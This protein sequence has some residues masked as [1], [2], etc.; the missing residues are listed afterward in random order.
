MFKKVVSLFM[1][2]FCF[3]SLTISSSAKAYKDDRVLIIRNEN[4]DWNQCTAMPVSL[5]SEGM[6]VRQSE[7]YDAVYVNEM[8]DSF[9]KVDDLTYID[10]E[11]VSLPL[12]EYE[13]YLTLEGY[14]LPQEVLDSVARMAT[15]ANETQNTSA[16]VKFY[17]PTSL[18]RLQTYPRTQTTWNGK[19]FY[20]YQ[21]YFTDMY[22][23]SQV[24]SQGKSLSESVLSSIVEMIISVVGNKSENLEPVINLFSN[25]MSALEFWEESTGNTPIY[26]YASNKLEVDVCYDLYHKYTFYDDPNFGEEIFGCS[27]QKGKIKTVETTEYLYTENGGSRE[28]NTEIC[29]DWYYTPNFFSP[30]Q[31]AYYHTTSGWSE[32]LRAKVANK[33]FYF[34][35]PD[36]SWPTTWPTI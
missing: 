10:V 35:A 26:G 30:E 14:N 15:L 22:T 1:A 33:T 4:G 9:L 32:R 28:V 17:M 27:S 3:L 6:W 21:V 5:E 36:F 8:G 18:T 2:V 31:V 34:E 13:T 23:G 19:T 24:I 12:S 16:K 29:N 7:D 20:H 25:G 11:E